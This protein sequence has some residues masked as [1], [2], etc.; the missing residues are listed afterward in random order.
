MTTLTQANVKVEP[1]RVAVSDRTP[2]SLV[3]SSTT[4]YEVRGVAPAPDSSALR[5]RY[6]GSLLAKGG[7]NEQ[8]VGCDHAQ[9]WYS[10]IIKIISELFWYAGQGRSALPMTYS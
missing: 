3:S 4:F 1:H 8:P 5:A 2:G 7:D 9:R 10:G 6:A